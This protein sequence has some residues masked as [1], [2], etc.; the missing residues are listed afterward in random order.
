MYNANRKFL[1]KPWKEKLYGLLLLTFSHKTTFS[2]KEVYT[3]LGPILSTYYEDSTTI[4]SSI[5]KNLQLLRDE[6]KIMFLGDGNY[7]WCDR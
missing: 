4:K 2:S 5:R 1:S 7:G 3:I 6:E